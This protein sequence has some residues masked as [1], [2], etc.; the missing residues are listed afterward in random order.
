MVVKK[1]KQFFNA[2]VTVGDDLTLITDGSILG[3]GA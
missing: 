2:D 3:F 1:V